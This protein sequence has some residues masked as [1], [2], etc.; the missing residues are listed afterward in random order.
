MFS[1]GGIVQPVF[2]TVSITLLPLACPLTRIRP[3]G[4]LY[5]RAFSRRFCTISDV[6]RFSP[7]TNRPR[8]NS[9]SIFARRRQNILWIVPALRLSKRGRLRPVFVLH[10]S[11]LN[12]APAFSLARKAS[13]RPDGLQRNRLTKAARQRRQFASG[14]Y[15]ALPENS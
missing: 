1:P 7:A 8:G 13:A 3:P 4:R 10:D 2:P 12:P 5:F 11:L 14:A 9:F 6:Y 15:A